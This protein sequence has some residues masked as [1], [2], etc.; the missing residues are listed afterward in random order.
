M[1]GSKWIADEVKFESAK[2]LLHTLGPR[3]ELWKPHSSEWVFRGISDLEEHKLLPTAYRPGAFEGLIDPSHPDTVS[4]RPKAAAEC[5]INELEKERWLVGQFAEKSSEAGLSLPLDHPLITRSIGEQYED[6]DLDLNLWALWALA[7]HHGLPSSLLDWTRRPL[8]AA[9]FA[10]TNS[11]QEKI[12]TGQLGVWALRRPK[13]VSCFVEWD[14][15][16]NPPRIGRLRF[17]DPQ[18]VT[19]PNLQA[20]SGLFTIL[21]VEGFPPVDKYIENL[22]DH[23][24]ERMDR[25]PPIMRLFS[26]PREH[27]SELLRLLSD[28]GIHGASM[29]PGYDGVVRYLKER[30]QHGSG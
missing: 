17:Y 19:N 23:E 12:P 30:A 4:A 5:P 25:P 20:Q 28:E 16:Y 11:H 2:E 8:V 18:T 6:K 7:R 27:A 13:Q 21:R 29:F 26:L 14:D 15:D 10:A 9:Y 3:N 22:D 24:L 1:R